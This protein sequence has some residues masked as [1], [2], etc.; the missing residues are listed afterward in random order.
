MATGSALV[1]VSR[2]VGM[3]VGLS[4]LSS[5]GVR[6]F[7]ALAANITTPIVRPS[8]LTDAQWQATKDAAAAATKAAAHTVFSEFFLIAAIVIGVAVIP[9]LFFY[10]HKS[11]GIS[12]LPFHAPLM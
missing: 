1:T 4:A 11:R 12:H 6:R 10:K 9:A 7:N 2:M 8:G 3:V 5:W